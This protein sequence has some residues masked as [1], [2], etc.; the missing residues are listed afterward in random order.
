MLL[1]VLLCRFQG[2]TGVYD[3]T[4]GALVKP[5]YRIYYMLH[6]VLDA[7]S[8]R[9]LGTHGLSEWVRMA[10]CVGIAGGLWALV[11]VAYLLG[12]RLWFRLRRARQEPAPEVPHEI[13]PVSRRAFFT[14]LGAGTSAMLACGAAYPVVVSPEAVRTVRHTLCIKDWP[15]ALEGLRAV[16]LTDTH[17]GP[18][19]SLG[20]LNRVIQQT[21][22]LNP[23]LVL[24]T[25]DYV[26]NHRRHVPEGIRLFAGLRSKFGT[27]AVLG[28][29]DHWVGLHISR[30]IFDEIGVP[31]IDN[32]R[33][34]LTPNGF[35]DS[36]APDT[37]C[38]AGVGDLW[39]DAVDFQAALGGV[40][41]D[42]P[43]LLLA[44]NPDVAEM[45]N[46][47]RVDAMF[48]GHTHGGQVC[49]PGLGPLAYSTDYG[50]KYLAGLCEGPWTTAIVSRGIGVVALP[51][52]FNCPAELVEITF[53]RA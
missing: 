45:D 26:H 36:P 50:D 31:L 52:R 12:H 24:L 46:A 49:V 41:E 29:H 47:Y 17:Y 33:R 40:P 2:D 22:A 28:N 34:F 16:Q 38:I 39:C 21:N 4:L 30:M 7:A 15:A 6:F 42:M 13:R 35:S 51:I 18:M 20:Y 19:I 53:V 44:H 23:D 11:C 25:G 27:V 14:E 10:I 48:S 1:L 5:V 43:R 32:S 8:Q 37:V 3:D 9:L